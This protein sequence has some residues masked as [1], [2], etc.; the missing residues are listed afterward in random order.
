MDTSAPLDV[1]TFLKVALTGSAALGG[2]VLALFACLR[3]DSRDLCH[4]LDGFVDK[5][6]SAELEPSETWTPRHLSRLGFRLV[7]VDG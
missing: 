7:R 5:L 4:R 3:S 1:G 2:V 6:G